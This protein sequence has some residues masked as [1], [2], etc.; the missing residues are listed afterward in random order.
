M[1]KNPSLPTIGIIAKESQI[2]RYVEE[3][4][5]RGAL[6]RLIQP[7]TGLPSYHSE[8]PIDGLIFA[9]KLLYS[10]LP[11]LEK[12]KS[13]W[14]NLQFLQNFLHRRIPIL[15]I[16]EGMH[17]LH[18]VFQHLPTE[19]P[20]E[21]TPSLLQIPRCDPNTQIFISPGSKLAAI[22]GCGGFF[23]VD[24]LNCPKFPMQ[25]INRRFMVNAYSLQRNWIEGIE[26]T[27]H[28]WAI[29]INWLPWPTDKSSRAFIALFSSLIHCSANTPTS[30]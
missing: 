22:I 19:G 12:S 21:E 8:D 5:N 27:Q 23:K 15:A 26:G 17:A 28:P 10:K 13:A 18:N 14:T 7:R 25:T 16:G 20:P 4:E 9:D 24:I 6:S 2:R 29:G 11:N 30:I 3:V 1:A